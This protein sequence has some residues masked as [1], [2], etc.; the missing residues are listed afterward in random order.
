M[1]ISFSAENFMSLK[2]EV[3]FSMETGLRLRKYKHTNTFQDDNE[4]VLK[5]AILVGPNGSGK[6]NILSALRVMKSLIINPTQSATAVLPYNPF[7]MSENNLQKPTTFSIHFKTQGQEYIYSMSYTKNEVV[8]EELDYFLN[9]TRQIYFSRER[10]HFTQISESLKPYTKLTRPNILFLNV[11]Q[12]VNDTRAIAVLNWFENDL[13]FGVD[14]TTNLSQL[15]Y[16][17]KDPKNKQK[18]LHFLKFADINIEDVDVR[19]QAIP[20][21]V[22][23]VLTK[24]LSHEEAEHFLADEKNITTLYVG[25]K[26]YDA[27][28]QLLDELRYIPLVRDSQ[29]TQNLLGIALAIINANVNDNDKTLLFDEFDD[30]LHFEIAKALLSV[31]NSKVNK[32]QFILTTHDLA[33]L[34]CNLRRDQ[35]YFADKDFQGETKLYSLFDFKDITTSRK[36]FSYYHKYL[37]GMFGAMPTVQPDEME[38]SLS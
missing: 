22:I 8:T 28:G 13:L 36:D 2:N 37:T 14:I 21:R 24:T 23:E 34:D 20:K 35:I 1:L 7:L 26:Q 27:E 32:N 19:E 31:F 30:S 11:A 5:S 38:K 25:Y 18:L 10:S 3:E 6:T 16:L 12:N 9:N 15:Y 4:A 33:L 29:G 17:L